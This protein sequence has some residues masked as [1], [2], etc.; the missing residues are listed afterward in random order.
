[1]IDITTFNVPLKNNE[2]EVIK[3]DIRNGKN[4][5]KQDYINERRGKIKMIFNY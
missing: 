4:I 5:V 2:N 3:Y 1:M